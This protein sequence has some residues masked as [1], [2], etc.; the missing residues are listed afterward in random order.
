[1]PITYSIAIDRNDDGD[2]TDLSEVISADVLS[3]QWRL[4]L[5][6][7]YDAVAAPAVAEITV[8]NLVGAYSPERNALLPAKRL[9]I[10]SNDGTTTRTHFIGAVERVEPVAGEYS[11]RT[12]RIIAYGREVEVAANRVRV[13]PMVDVT[14]D[15]VLDALFDRLKLRYA[16]IDG[17]CIIDNTGFNLIDSTTIFPPDVVTRN[18]DT[19]KSTFAYVGADWST[20][21]AADNAL[22]EVVESE[23]GRFFFNRAG[24]AVFYNRHHLF[25]TLTTQASF[26]DDMDGLDY[27]YGADRVNEV[28]VRLR[29][30][31]IGVANTLIWSLAQPLKIK[32]G[33]THTLITRYAIDNEPVALVSAL[34]FEHTA[35]RSIL[36]SSFEVTRNVQVVVMDAGFSAATIEVRNHDT[37]DTYL[38]TLNLYGTPLLTG[39]ILT[40]TE[41]DSLAVS[42]Y[43]VRV[44]TVDLPALT[45]TE[46]AAAL[47]TYE[48]IRRSTPRGLITELHSSTRTHPAQTLALTLFDRIAIAETQTGHSA[49]YRI[50]AE[51]HTVDKGGTRHRVAWLLEPDDSEIFF[52]VNTHNINGDE[53]L[54]PR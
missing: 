30:R 34:R 51:T 24:E 10:Q 29:P 20:G 46:E 14:A 6:Q 19:G 9:R 18:F 25:T 39:D 32:F 5:Q 37:Q 13:Q 42:L 50:V 11:S 36:P 3:V 52:V 35:R 38:H 23:G 28:D 53:V 8:R 12:S 33:E 54:L 31:S 17:Y 15:T 41:R 2:F 27:A 40:L 26:S 21:I 7:R 4:G 1:M 43:G 47:A 45:D 44:Y 49:F 48:L 22:R 16:V